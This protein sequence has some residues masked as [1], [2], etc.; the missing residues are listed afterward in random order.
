MVILDYH[1]FVC[2]DSV[3]IGQIRIHKTKSVFISCF[4]GAA[5]N[6]SVIRQ[7]AKLFLDKFLQH[8][9]PFQ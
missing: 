6:V 5:G 3:L 1:K 7:A 2:D 8:P 9:T 4:F